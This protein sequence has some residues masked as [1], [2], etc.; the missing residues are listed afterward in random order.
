MRTANGEYVHVHNVLKK[1]GWTT[2]E[3]YGGREAQQRPQSTGCTFSWFIRRMRV[4]Q[5]SPSRRLSCGATYGAG[6]FASRALDAL[7]AGAVGPH[8]PVLPLAHLMLQPGR[9]P[10]W[11]MPR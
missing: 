9:E 2:L 5:R 1:A 3:S 6:L 4:C 8:P 11:E 7:C 10:C